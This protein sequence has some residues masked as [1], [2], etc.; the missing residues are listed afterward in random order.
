MKN[1]RISGI[2]LSYISLG[3]NT[4]VNLIYVPVLLHFLGK[5]EYGLYQL[6]GSFIAYFSIMD[7]GL[8]NTVIRYFSKYKAL[9]ETDKM[10]NVLAMAQKIYLV[11]DGIIVIFSIIIYPLIDRF[12]VNTLTSYELESAKKIYIVVIINI[13]ITISFN[14]YTAFITAQ[15]EFIFIK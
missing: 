7:F 13:L 10:E 6:M 12:Y 14:V 5:S 2:V 9:N 1:Q 3:I 15:E 8:S 11:I 4:V